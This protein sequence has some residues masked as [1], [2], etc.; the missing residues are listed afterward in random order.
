VVGLGDKRG[1]LSDWLTQVWVRATGR[2]I[3]LADQT[4]L[5][6]PVGSPRGIGNQFFAYYA[7]ARGL[8]VV[9]DGIRGLIPD[10]AQL[11]LRNAGGVAS[12]VRQFYEHTS[13]YELDAWSDWSGF[14]T[15]F[16]RTLAL[17]FSRRLQQL[18]V[19]L[20]PLDSSKGMSSVVLQLRDPRSGAVQ[21][22]WVRELHATSN[23]YAGSYSICRV[24]GY[25]LPC[26][27]VVFPLPNGNAIVLMKPEVHPDGSFSVT[28]AGRRF[29]E[30]GFYFVLH[31][32]A[33]AACARYVPSLRESIRVY[34]AEGT[35]VRADHVFWIWG[36]RFLRLHYRMR[37]VGKTQL[38]SVS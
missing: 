38:M 19:P 1:Y 23:T 8:D 30:A 14:F 10:F 7:R 11:E 36:L 5:D 4:W 17:L 27:K 12:E 26:V 13:E 34:P 18:N 31:L 20:S 24:P 15:P 22:A 21:T 6:G 29:G 25:E 3:K 28:S 9:Q 16:G 35:T 37:F 2:N 33:S 32:R